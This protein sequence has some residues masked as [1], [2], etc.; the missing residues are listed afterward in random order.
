[1]Q[2][3]EKNLKEIENIKGILMILFKNK[4]GERD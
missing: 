4:A 1:M 3:I 2:T